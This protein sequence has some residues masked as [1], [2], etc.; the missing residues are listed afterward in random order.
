LEAKIERRTGNELDF[1]MIDKCPMCGGKIEK[2]NGQVD[3]YCVNPD[4]PR[5]NIESIIHYVSRDAMNIEG[6]GD[7]I[8]EELYN[9]GFV[10]KITDLYDLSSKKKQIMEFDGYGEKSLNKIIDNIEASKNSSLERLLFGLGI[11]EV[12]NKTAKILASNFE[13]MDNLMDAEQEF[14][15]ARKSL[16]KNFWG[17]LSAT[18][19][20]MGF[21]IPYFGWLFFKKEFRRY[22]RKAREYNEKY[23]DRS[24]TGRK[25]G[26]L[27]RILKSAAK[28]GAGGWVIMTVKFIPALF[29]SYGQKLTKSDLKHRKGGETG[30][31]VGTV[32]SSAVSNEGTLNV[33]EGVSSSDAAHRDMER[34]R[35]E[36]FG[37]FPG[38][39]HTLTA[40]AVSP[41]I[42]NDTTFQKTTSPQTPPIRATNKYGSYG[43]IYA[44][45]PALKILLL[46]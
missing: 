30:A 34:F 35:Q 20:C 15:D 7:E 45:L 11:K 27:V 5:R 37:W 33:N 16:R 46:A 43:L 26:N 8:V 13:K 36:I 3:Y 23:G 22:D 28:A 10:R 4:C 38:A 44:I 18:I 17:L 14:K 1:V 19:L 42:R 31:D 29:K 39:V 9:L 24:N 32:R 41:A 25:Y 6:L 21:T 12:G 40:C 2:R